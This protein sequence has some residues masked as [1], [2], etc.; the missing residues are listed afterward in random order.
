MVHIFHPSSVTHGYS[1]LL[2]VCGIYIIHKGP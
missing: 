1:L 2:K